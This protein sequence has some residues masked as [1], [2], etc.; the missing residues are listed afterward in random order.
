MLVAQSSQSAADLNDRIGDLIDVSG[1]APQASM[2][3]E[4]ANCLDFA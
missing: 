3:R 1:L 2:R 4:D